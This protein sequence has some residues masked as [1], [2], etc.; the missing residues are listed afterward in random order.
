MMEKLHHGELD[1]GAFRLALYA[2]RDRGRG[3]RQILNTA[4]SGFG[5]AMICEPR[6]Y[7]YNLNSAV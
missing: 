6:L 5:A 2:M 3:E 1:W 7:L 4:N